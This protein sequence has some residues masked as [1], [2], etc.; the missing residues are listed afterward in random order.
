MRIYGFLYREVGGSVH[1]R[2]DFRHMHVCGGMCG[3]H[4]C[5]QGFACACVPVFLFLLCPLLFYA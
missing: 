3:F 5:M 4:A 1:G 2:V